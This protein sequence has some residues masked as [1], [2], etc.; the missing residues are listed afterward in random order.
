MKLVYCWITNYLNIKDQGFNFGSEWIY[1]TT[2]NSKK[3][4]TIKRTK[5]EKYVDDFFK[6]DGVGFENVTAIVEKME[7]G[8]VIFWNF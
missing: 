4:L 5:N 6:L 2:V 8:K 3:S 7:L 1:T